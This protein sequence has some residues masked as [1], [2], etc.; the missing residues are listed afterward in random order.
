MSK[1]GEKMILEKIDKF[2][3][4]DFH[5]HSG[6][7]YSRDYTNEEFLKKLESVELDCIAI[8]DHN[9]IDIELYNEIKQNNKISKLLIGGVELNIRIDEEEIKKFKL[10]VSEGIEY[11]H[12]ILLFDYKDIEN[13]WKKLLTNIIIKNNSEIT[14]NMPVGEISKAL[15]GKSFTLSEIQKELQ[16]IEYYFVFHENKG[17][18]NLSDY[19]KNGIK[20]N[21]EYKEKLFYYN[22]ACAI[23]G[24]KKN[25]KICSALSKELNIIVSRFFFSDAKTIEEIGEKYTWINF[26]G[27]FSNLILPFSDPET[28]IFTS[29][30]NSSNP[31]KNTNYLSEIKMS[32]INKIANT[33]KEIVLHFSPGLNGIIGA[34][35]SGKSM[36]GNVL[37]GK[38]ISKY[39][40]YLEISS[41]EYKMKDCDFTKNIP[42]SKYL[43]Q[44]ELL[45]IYE[46]EH[47]SELDFIKETYKSILEDKKDNIEKI[48]LDINNNL[49]KEKNNILNFYEKYNNIVF[50]DFLK[51]KKTES[52]LLKTIESSSF[53]NNEQE[54]QNA[55]DVLNLI[56]QNIE[57]N[58]KELEK[59]E[60]S[61]IF[62][63]S[64]EL[65]EQLEKTKINSIK[66]FRDILA[67]IEATIE[68]F[69][70][71]DK[72]IF[73]DRQKLIE[74]FSTL[75][76]QFNSRI[77]NNANKQKEDI[78]LLKNFFADL[79]ILRKEIFN[80]YKENEENYKKI[81]NNQFNKELKLNEESSI[82]LKT[83]V[84]EEI[85]YDEIIKEQLKIDN[86]EYSEY[87]LDII[88]SFNEFDK[89]KSKFNGVRYRNINTFE[90]YIN[91]YFENIQKRISVYNNIGLE[92]LYNDKELSKYSPGKR[93]E[94]L[95]EIF[96]HYEIFDS[97]EYEYIILDQPEDNLDTNTIVNIL[98]NKIRKM[99][100]NKQLFVIS[101]SAP[102]IINSDSNLIICS[103][104]KNNE[105]HYDSGNINDKELK[106]KIVT[107]L[108]GG[109]KNLKMRL[110]KYNFTYKGE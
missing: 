98:V 40:D 74:M 62:K 57:E 91:K 79:Y 93:S 105:I 50:W 1:E 27:E 9:I 66:R 75:L 54:Y 4:C 36:L 59:L 101:H 87:I 17:D 97:N 39:A 77:D 8:T 60:F 90:E 73:R 72:N 55:T 30:L 26:N 61:N 31:Q 25:Q 5:M 33:Q 102:V 103:E 14:E 68:F 86:I 38:E 10:K 71:S 7:C 3:K 45:K 6:T 108:D 48:I 99:K 85:K 13:I 96:L 42:K 89:F 67:E 92:I 64:K 65:H 84:E 23:E 24:N 12:G 80:S 69:Q 78:E 41:I 63:E 110:N 104:Q 58:I 52:K 35:G 15:E 107:I 95:L 49:E 44:N 109:E 81:F 28:R 94:I 32:L 76:S 46:E 56:K 22:E 37:S 51:N 100:L 70:K 19:L 83:K 18:R 88:F 11:F 47:F 20:S 82:I 29:D 16:D 34:R 21:E 53:K 106:E 43:R 2:L